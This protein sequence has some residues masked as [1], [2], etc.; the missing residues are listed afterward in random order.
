MLKIIVAIICNLITALVVICGILTS[1][2]GGWRVALAKLTLTLG[3]GVGVYF[4]TPYISNKLWCIE[5]VSAL[6]NQLSISQATVNSCIF[7]VTF[8]LTYAFVCILCT[9]IKHILVRSV[10]KLTTDNKARLKRAK[11]INPKAERASKRQLW[12]EL[13]NEFKARNKWYKRLIAVL[14]GLVTHCLVV[15]VL[16]LPINYIAKDL[17]KV[18]NN[19][20][21]YIDE[22][23]AY[24][25]NGVVGDGIMDWVIS[26][27]VSTSDDSVEDVPSEEPTDG[28][29]VD[30][31]SEETVE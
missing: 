13:N 30:T 8:L 19:Q 1:S 21:S 23:Y 9:F 31:P 10:R 3:A 6:A 18:S 5:G 14:M 4:L 25:L 26:A 11:S 2:K 7:F 17:N 20:Y 16:L 27:P 22:G 12:R 29:V 24:T 15:F 28:D